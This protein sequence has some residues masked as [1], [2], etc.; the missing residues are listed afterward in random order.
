MKFFDKIMALGTKP[1]QS[2]SLQH[3]IKLTNGIAIYFIGMV[4]VY[5][6]ISIALMPQILPFVIVSGIFYVIVPFINMSGNYNLARFI[7]AVNPALVSFFIHISTIKIGEEPILGNYLVQLS[8]TILPWIVFDLKDKLLLISSFIITCLCI[9]LVRSCNDW[10]EP[11]ITNQLARSLLLENIFLVTSCTIIAITLYILQNFNQSTEK[12]NISLIEDSRLQNEKMLENEK[13]L[14]DYIKQIEDSRAEDK[15]REWASAGLAKF[16]EILRENN[17]DISKTYDSVMSN[18]VKY[19]EANQG[20]LF[21]YEEDEGEPHL[22][23]VACYAYSRKKYE[24]RKIAIGE[25]LL[26]Q[27]FLEKKTI[28]LTEIPQN[29]T[30]IT[31]GLGDATP[32]CLIIV[33][34]IV[35]EKIYGVMEL[36]AFAV[37]EKYKVE[38]LEK[39]GETLASAISNLKVNEK[40][41]NLLAL[42]MQQTEE[43]RAQEEEMRQNMEELTA[44]QEEMQR[45]SIEIEEIRAEEKQKAEEQLQSKQKQLDKAKVI[46]QELRTKI[47]ELEGKI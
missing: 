11:E 2:F 37:F 31:S 14:N 43:M 1:E 34:L 36:A 47:K 35:N 46:E 13:K 17:E 6:G 9:I 21:V 45:K 7:A 25:G 16:S 27:C 20:G 42:S 18:L 33:P 30:Y 29:Y 12:Q 3:K 4:F 8:F 32:T 39:I 38:F 19:L 24:D 28:M 15:K 41:K 5:I 44:T 10:V 23:L 40:T 22:S 26:G